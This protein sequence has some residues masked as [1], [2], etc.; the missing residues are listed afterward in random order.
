MFAMIFGAEFCK[1]GNVPFGIRVEER[2]RE[3]ECEELNWISQNNLNAA[4]L[5][6]LLGFEELIIL[7]RL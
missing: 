3:R 7:N 4:R 2:E 1:Y 5:Q 6:A